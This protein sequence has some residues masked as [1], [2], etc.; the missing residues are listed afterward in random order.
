[1]IEIFCDVPEMMVEQPPNKTAPT[2]AAV[3]NNAPM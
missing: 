3:R 1:V 2:I